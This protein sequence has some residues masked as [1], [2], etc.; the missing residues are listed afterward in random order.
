MNED[1]LNES[2][3]ADRQEERFEKAHNRFHTP[4]YYGDHVRKIFFGAGLLMLFALPF[5][6]KVSLMGVIVSILG[7]LTVNLLAGLT[8]PRQRAMI[9]F[10]VLVS[11]LGMLIFELFAIFRFNAYGNVFDIYFWFNEVLAVLFFISL[12]LG[13]KTLRGIALKDEEII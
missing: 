5:F 1:I 11:L 4:H 8:S 3:V 7:I 9:L 2:S 10:D 6:S 13:M 12:Y